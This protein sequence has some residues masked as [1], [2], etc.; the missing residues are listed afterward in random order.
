[1]LWLQYLEYVDTLKL[2]IQAERT[3]NWNLH[4]IAVEKMLNL[5]AATGHINYAKSARLYLQQMQ[6]LPTEHP[7]LYHCFSEQ[8][9]HTVRRS[10]RYWAGL[11]TD[12]IIEQVMM[13]SI[14]SRARGRGVTENVR[15]QW[16]YSMHKCAGV[17][18]AMT[19]A[20]GLKHR[21]SEQHIE[22]GTSRSKRD[23]EDLKKIQEWL[24]QHD[25]FNPNQPKL[26]SLSS[27]LTAADDDNVNCDQ[28]KQVGANIHKKLDDMNVIDASIKRS[29][30]VRSL[31]QLQPSVQVDK[32]SSYKPNATFLKTDCS[33]A[34]RED[35]ALYFEYELTTIP[36]SVFKDNGLRKTE[37]AQL[38]RFL[39][40]D[41][42][43]SELSLQAKYVLDGG[44]LIRLNGKEGNIPRHSE[45]LC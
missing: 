4:L 21:T 8:G 11:W 5:F 6:Q 17:H 23:Y 18:D 30:Q 14:K 19:T 39:K 34:E 45:A 20:T 16:I 13:R 10:S 15:I 27:G 1:M 35:M 41:V 3:G 28:T 2:F 38:G 22:I 31:N 40:I 33:G 9:F 36:T 37:K 44:A 25:P 43:P 12:L 26:F 7:W 29:D 32:K 24:N 42:E